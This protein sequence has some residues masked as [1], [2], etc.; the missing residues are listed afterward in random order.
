MPYECPKV[1]ELESARLKIR[2]L[3]DTVQVYA[4][5]L[6]GYRRLAY[7]VAECGHAY[8]PG[9]VFTTP[10]AEDLGISPPF[11]GDPDE[12]KL[13]PWAIAKAIDWYMRKLHEVFQAELPP[14]PVVWVMDGAIVDKYGFELLDDEGDEMWIDKAAFT[15]WRG[16]GIDVREWKE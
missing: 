3:Q 15:F 16:K 1:N 13:S 4:R 10:T 5:M 14:R 8:P 2:D 6:Q 12:G 9:T 7:R 11:E